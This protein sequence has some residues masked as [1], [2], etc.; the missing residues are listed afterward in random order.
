VRGL[1]DECAARL[2]GA[3]FAASA[4]GPS[5]PPSLDASGN[6]SGVAGTYSTPNP[7]AALAARS[8]AQVV[9]NKRILITSLDLFLSILF[10]KE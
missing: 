5:P 10:E 9:R 8:A 7:A 4:S 2:A 3:T 6:P 1:E